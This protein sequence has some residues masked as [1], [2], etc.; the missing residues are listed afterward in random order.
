MWIYKHLTP[1]KCLNRLETL[2]E[3][4]ASVWAVL[5]HLQLVHAL[6]PVLALPVGLSQAS[7][8]LLQL[9]IGP[10]PASLALRAARLEV[11]DF[12]GQI[13]P[14]L[15]QDSFGLLQGLAGLQ[16]TPQQAT[17]RGG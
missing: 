8:E 12:L 1:K 14:L 5:L 6:L 13:L 3:H 15:L 17:I 16:E 4:I 11:L 7:V 9:T 10:L 2:D